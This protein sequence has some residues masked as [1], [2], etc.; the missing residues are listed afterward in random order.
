[1][2]VYL[3]GSM[4]RPICI[5]A[6]LSRVTVVNALAGERARNL[7]DVTF[8][9]PPRSRPGGFPGRG[10]A[11]GFSPHKEPKWQPSRGERF[12]R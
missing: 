7:A 2:S 6:P 12:C 5:D 1:M 8:C 4:T 10:A 9:A 11:A 3:A